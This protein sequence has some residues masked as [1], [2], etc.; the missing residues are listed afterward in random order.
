MKTLLF[1][2]IPLLCFANSCP[3][4]FDKWASTAKVL[5][6]ITGVPASVQLAQAYCETNFGAKDTIGYSRE[7][8]ERSYRDTVGYYFNNHF[9]IMDF[10]NDYWEF[11]NNS[12]NGCWGL[13]RYCWRWYIHP[14]VSWIDHAY[15]LWLHNPKHRHKS[16]QYWCN[17]PVRYGRKGYWGK[18]RRTIVRYNLYQY[19]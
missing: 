8:G 16:W 2:L 17:N 7:S 19:D 14:I 3:S 9:A 1:T 11:G 13:R 4:N 18:I 12:A 5:Q 15:F 6:V 10:K